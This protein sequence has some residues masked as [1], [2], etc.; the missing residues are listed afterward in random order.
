MEADAQ[1]ARALILRAQAGD[2]QAQAGLWQSH[3][4][5]V[6]AIVL[7]HRPRTI[8]VDDLMQDVAIKFIDK[9]STLR[10]PAAFRP[11][12]RQIVINVCRGAARSLKPTLRLAE[13]DR[14]PDDGGSDIVS[15]A[16]SR[17]PTASQLTARDDSANRLLEQLL[18]LPPEYREP[19][20][21]R[22]VHSMTYQQISAILELPVTTIE[23]R[24][25][26][27]RR[28]LREEIK[29]ESMTFPIA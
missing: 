25:A 6:A 21:L 23:T 1:Q 13:V 18:S 26:R 14:A 12:L 20:L 16:V 27:G 3:S 7:A 19:L 11:W 29:E 5:W 22:C 4:R 2:R 10:E 8:D 28:M 17:Q 15:P 9:V 24:L